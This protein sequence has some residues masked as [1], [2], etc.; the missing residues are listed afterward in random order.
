MWSIESWKDL[1]KILLSEN[2]FPV[3]L[4]GELEHEKN[5]EL[6][7]ETGALYLGCFSLEE[8]IAITNSMDLV[9][10][11]VSMMMHIATALQKKMVLMNNIFNKNEFELYGR[12][13]IVSP[14]SEC[15]CYYGNTCK[16]GES[17]MNEIL[18]QT[19]VDTIKRNC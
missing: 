7:K 4:G 17:C 6:S 16:K 2:Y 18:P 14:V 8:F 11:Q 10:T 12:G 3:F 15:V 19:I 1:T 13:E 5:L 9:L